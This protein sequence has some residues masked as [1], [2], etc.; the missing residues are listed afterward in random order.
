[1]TLYLEIVMDE[2]I[3]PSEEQII[4]V[5]RNIGGFGWKDAEIWAGFCDAVGMDPVPYLKVML[6]TICRVN[7]CPSEGAIPGRCA[8]GSPE[9]WVVLRGGQTRFHIVLPDL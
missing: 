4:S 2:T 6:E 5:F 1:M 8:S 7:S 9:L 3:S